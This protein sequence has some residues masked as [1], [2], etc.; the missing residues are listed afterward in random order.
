MRLMFAFLCLLMNAPSVSFT[1]DV[2]LSGSVKEKR[3]SAPISAALVELKKSDGTLLDTIRTDGY[4]NWSYRFQSSAVGPDPSLPQ[5]FALHQ[6]YPNPFNP[7]TTI[8]FSVR[9]AGHVRFTVYNILGQ[10][11]DVK[12]LHLQ[13]GDYSIR[14]NSRGS[15]GALFYSMEMDGARITRKMIQL[16]G[17]GKGGFST[18]GQHS[19]VASFSVSSNQLT[20]CWVVAG[21]ILH[22]PDS[23]FVLLSGSPRAD[24][25]LETVHDR[26][27]VIDLHNDILEQ[28]AAGGFQ[29]NIGIRNTT[30][31]LDLP[32]MQDGGL[33]AQQF[34]IWINPTTYPTNQFARTLQFMDSLKVQFQRNNSMIGVAMTSSQIDSIAQTGKLVGVLMVEGGHSIEDN[35]ENLRTLYVQG[36]RCMT[37]TWNNSTSWAV[38]AQDSRTNTVGLSDF[39]KQVIRTMDSLGMIID[40]SHVGIKT[41]DDI[42]ATSTNPIIASHSG[43]RSLCNV[44]RN[45]TDAQIVS[46]AQRGGVI[47]VVFHKGFLTSGNTANIDTVI[48]HI[49]Y[50]KNLVG[51]DYISLGSDFDG[52]IT[53]PIGL[54]DVTKFPALTAALLQKGYSRGDVRKILGENYLRVYRAICR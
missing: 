13:P 53:P 26:A 50:I 12:D 21:D 25:I 9:T 7:S 20:S 24:F 16:E 17:G 15:T 39:G 35:L 42:L 23:V 3:S 52:G 19:A 11:L 48:K 14:W 54:N 51:V 33:D 5:S 30:N 4:G 36:V 8:P 46:I 41:I 27:F 2:I 49:D 37:I 43:C 47:G 31:Q 32:R 22:E 34:S 1:Q 29:Y 6:N 44:L 45:L 18:V 10:L 28:M 40:V 38:S